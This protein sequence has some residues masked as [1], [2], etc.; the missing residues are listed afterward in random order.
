[1]IIMRRTKTMNTAFS[2]KIIT[3][4]ILLMV[5]ASF[6]TV[7][8][9]KE[10][11]DDNTDAGIVLVPSIAQGIETVIETRAEVSVS[12]TQG[13][14]DDNLMPNGTL[15]RVFAA[16]AKPSQ[17]DYNQEYRTA[18]SFRY[19]NDR[20]HSSVSAKNDQV[21]YYLYAI[22]PAF[23][24]G[25]TESD[26]QIFNW[27]MVNG[28]TGFNPDSAKLA[29]NSISVITD[30]DPM[31][32]I[33]ASGR[34]A[35]ID[36]TGT[37]VN[38]D[39]TALTTPPVNP[40][41]TKG[42]F[43]V[44][45]ISGTGVASD[46]GLTKIHKVWMAMDHLYAKVTLWFCIDANY[47]YTIRIKDAKILTQHSILTGNDK[48]IYSFKDG[49]KLDKD[50]H[51]AGNPDS[52]SL[53][54]G[55]TAATDVFDSHEVDYATLTPEYKKYAWFCFLPASYVPGLDYPSSWIKVIYDVCDRN[56]DWVRSDTVQ[57]NFPLTEFFR[58]DELSITPQP[59]DH[60]NVKVKI[61]PTY[62]YQLSD[63]APLELE[64]S[65]KP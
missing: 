35:T 31:V 3:R 41:L 26:D 54:T 4:C 14:Y 21:D 53:L 30:S 60:F 34:G 46:N 8:C 43:G 23:L 18:G 57:N 15:L 50:S 61:R 51:F 64:I 24:P 11:L 44:G 49:L 40:P 1:M 12:G 27:G 29:I 32:N 55:P 63:D 6:V 42:S 10:S 17:G 7:S 65:S 25:V 19:S 33:A 2:K 62:L 56:G 20:W 37:E 9:Q 28:G 38:P 13:R 22:T 36:G 39:G 16:P 45:M 47:P 58:D 59:N 52:I 5:S 48:H